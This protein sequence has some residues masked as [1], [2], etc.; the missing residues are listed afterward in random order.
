MWLSVDLCSGWK[1][2]CLTAVGL[3]MPKRCQAWTPVTGVSHP[4]QAGSS[5]ARVK[6]TMIT[7]FSCTETTRDPRL[8]V[9]SL[10]KYL[11]QS[12]GSVLP[13][14]LMNTKIKVFPSGCITWNLMGFADL[15]KQVNCHLKQHPDQNKISKLTEMK[16]LTLTAYTSAPHK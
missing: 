6:I 2:G 5:P 1:D 11:S 12:P 7:V 13:A 10:S 15:G 3:V 4:G 9:W 8:R 16:C 14:V